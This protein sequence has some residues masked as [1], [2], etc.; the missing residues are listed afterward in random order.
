M[1]PQ[2]LSAKTK[3]VGGIPVARLIPQ[4][5]RRTIGA[6]C[7]LYHAGPAEFNA[8]SDGLQSVRIRIPTC[9]PSLGCLKANYGTKTAWATAS[10]SAPNKS[11]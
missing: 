7:F 1:N 3:G 9:K 5:G 11:I 8:F 10:L 6:W 2:K 4:A